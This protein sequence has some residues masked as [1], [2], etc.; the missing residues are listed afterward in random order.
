MWINSAVAP[1][2]RATNPLPWIEG[3]GLLLVTIKEEFSSM[4]VDKV[5]DELVSGKIGIRT[6][7]KTLDENAVDFEYENGKN[8]YM[9]QTGIYYKFV[10]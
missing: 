2:K 1:L 9:F 10:F 4:L 6:L 8:D 3:S 5:Y 7:F